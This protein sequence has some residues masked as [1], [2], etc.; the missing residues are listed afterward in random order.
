[1]SDEREEGHDKADALDLARRLLEAAGKTTEGEWRAELDDTDQ[2]RDIWADDVDGEPLRVA[3]VDRDYSDDDE[4][5]ANAR[6]IA[7]SRTAAPA[8]AQYALDAS[9]ELD[10]LREI[11][12]YENG[13]RS[14]KSEPPTI[15]MQADRDTPFD[16]IIHGEATPDRLRR[17]ARL[18]VACAEIM[19]EGEPAPAPPGETE[20]RAPSPPNGGDG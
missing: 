4:A 12:A 7:L 10:Q 9:A 5:D 11:V 1:M 19:D 20:T 2:L 3:L 17:I 16:L 18:I 6:F 15:R 8:L 13:R 14:A